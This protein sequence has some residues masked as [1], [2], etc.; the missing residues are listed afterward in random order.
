MHQFKQC[1][2]TALIF[3]GVFTTTTSCSDVDDKPIVTP[4]DPFRGFYSE[5]VNQLID[6]NYQVVQ[7]QGYG[8]LII[9][10]TLYDRSL[11]YLPEV[12]C[13]TMDIMAAN[14]FKTY[15]NGGAV[16]DG[17]LGTPIHDV[18]FSTDA[19][20]EQM[21]AIVPNTT[22]ATTN[23]GQIAQAHHDNG[24][25]TDMVPIHGIDIRL[26]GK[27]GMPPNGAY[28]ETYSKNLLDDTYGRDLTI[29]SI[30]FDYQTGNI[31]DYHGGL[32]DLR[33][34]IIRTV[35][36]ANL[37]F[38]I[39]PSAIIRTVRFAARYGYSIDE[40]TGQAISNNMQYCDELEP[41][42]VNYYITKGF[43]DGCAKRTY[44]YYLDYGLIDRYL[45]MLDGYARNKSY[46]DRLFPAFDYMDEQG[47][48][49]IA[50]GVATLLLPCMED[51]MTDKEP[52]ME[53][54][55][56]TWDELEESSGQK[57][58]CELDDYSGTKTD[59]LNIWYLY[60]QMTSDL[61]LVNT[62]KK[63]A[64][65]NS[66]YFKR[67]M[68]LLGGYAKSDATLQTCFN[69]WS[70]ATAEPATSFF[71]E[72]VNTLIDRNYQQVLQN[73]YAELRIPKT[74]YDNSL[75]TFPATA[76]SDMQDMLNAGYKVY[77]N[78]GTVRD[79]VM[80]KEAHDVDF[81]TD[82]DIMKI[83]EILPHAEVFHAFR[84]IW[85]AKAYHGDELETDIAP[86]F[87]I[88]PELSGKADIPVSRFPDSPY[89]DDL[90]E[91]TYS[92]DYTFNAMYYD[93]STGDIIDYHG[94]LHDLREGI[95]KTVYNADLSVSTDC[96]KYFR[97]CRFA[98]KYDFSI[99]ADLDA[100]LKKNYEALNLLDVDNAVYQTESG[101]NG[102]FSK[103]FFHLLN[104]YRLTDFLLGS[105]KDYLHTTSYD[106]YVE[107]VL[108]AFDQQGKTDMALTYAAIFWPYIE[109]NTKGNTTVTMETMDGL[110]SAIDAANH[111][112]FRFEKVSY[113]DYS[114]VPQYLKDVWLLQV[115][116]TSDSNMTT[117][118][119][120]QIKAM[121][122]F[123]DALRFLKARAVS[124]SSLATSVN[125]WD[126]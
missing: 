123:A 104:Y 111:E 103:K 51:A 40:A 4:D 16:R 68:S 77:V 100:A 126:E 57:A 37:M 117:E 10:A 11:I 91:D 76:T 119:A 62:S 122:H 17:I 80:G 54:I 42:L 14:G 7:S 109:E 82:A 35:Y 105:M 15:V 93:Y 69:Y 58:H 94:G 92:R 46:T 114:Y 32:H 20:P 86:I 106:N 36:D 26:K 66:N 88:F 64:I 60:M 38:P 34:H 125:Y 24:D 52:T 118:K 124:D 8:E 49:G 73:G 96:R 12:H 13:Q 70:T 99:A 6:E 110:W 90:L 74:M 72:A 71:S 101:F 39:N 102:G 3:C 33:E 85:V 22:I 121:S 56:S 5:A 97:A 78:G 44:Q 43:T 55:V 31:I 29:N 98:A 48:G 27:P 9:P 28:G 115:W 89:C 30:Y 1:F 25:V 21:V 107:G 41:A 50:L 2:F 95:V 75:F 67:A 65:L 47:G 120:A 59:L 19:T 113:G 18:D 112:V 53:N 87:S 84:D 108:E 63:T 23:G 83:T 61:A 79:G 116:M 45:K 81:S